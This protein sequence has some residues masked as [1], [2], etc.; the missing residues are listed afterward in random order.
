[1]TAASDD[2]GTILVPLDGSELAERALPVAERVARATAGTLLLARVVPI[3]R[4]AIDPPGLPLDPQLYRQLPEHIRNLLDREEQGALAYVGRVEAELRGRGLRVR[5]LV[6]RGVPDAT[7]LDL[8]VDPPIGLV[9]LASHGRTGLARFALGSMADRLARYGRA[10]V[11]VVRPFGEVGRQV[12]LERALV[13]LDG[14]AL[15]ELALA[16]VHALA[17]RVLRSATLVRVVDP[18]LRAGETA[19]ARRYLDEVR[20]RLVAEL[21]GR[22]CAIDS[23]VVY[24][25]TAEQILACSD[26]RDV[27]VMATHGRTGATRWALGSV[28]DRVLQ[29]VQIPLLLVRSRVVS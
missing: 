17:G 9:V 25:H 14:S 23:R 4:W 19:E 12:R 11:L 21:A 13:P 2:F 26:D 20:G 18:D 10:P 3:S 28:A 29:Q 1:M 24:G 7:L 8:E 16:M 22:E 5:S 15:A 6:E 27:V